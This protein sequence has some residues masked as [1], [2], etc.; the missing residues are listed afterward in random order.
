M[1]TT[2]RIGIQRGHLR[3]LLATALAALTVATTDASASHFRAGNLS[4][5]AVDGSAVSFEYT[6]AWRR[7]SQYGSG[8]DGYPVVGDVIE[9]YEGCI[10]PE[11]SAPDICPPYLV[12]ES[13]V[14]EDWIVARAL[15]DEND[16]SNFAV[17][18]SYGSAFGP[19]TALST[20]CCTIGELSN[21]SSSGWQIAT[22]VDLSDAGVP[23]SSVAP[24]VTLPSEA[25]I[26]TFS[27]A[28][29]SGS[30]AGGNAVRYR[31]ATSEEVCGSSG[32][33]DAQPP[34]FAV[35]PT[36]GQAQFDTTSHSGLWY[37]GVVIETYDPNYPGQSST[38]AP[39][40][41][42]SQVQFI[43]R[44]GGPPQWA[45]LTPNDGATYT[46][47]P[48]DAVGFDLTATDPDA[49]ES[50]E[51]TQTSGPG[52]LTTSEGNPATAHYTF[53]ASESDVGQ[54][55]QA[56]FEAA[57]VSPIPR[58]ADPRTVQ[59]RVVPRPVPE[60][61]RQVLGERELPPPVQGRTANFT[62]RT[63]E[64][65]V[66]L[67]PGAAAKPEYR[68][69][70]KSSAQAAG[71]APKG[72]IPLSE[73]RQLPVGSTLDTRRG[74][75]GLT[76]AGVGG[77][78]QSG[79]FSQG[80]FAWRQSAKS[81]LTTLTMKGA[82]SCKKPGKGKVVAAASRSRSIFGSGRGRFRTRGRRSSAT[83]RGTKWLQKDTCAGTLTVVREGSVSVKDLAK[84]KPIVLKA[85]GPKKNRRH[86]ARAPKR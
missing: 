4:W 75:V 29:V 51:I 23:R 16:L 65:F 21:V 62:P 63:G 73:A 7:S 35:D 69:A 6:Q 82:L 40:I 38:P 11:P 26:Q 25:G 71:S 46:V 45:A 85:N 58:F 13:H 28:A 30:Y 34:S 72:F 33:F 54:T 66:K 22:K 74:M 49:G 67:P 56:T 80:L 1:T 24:I 68:W 81:P 2:G 76:T 55:Y 19:F 61:E 86:F 39:A 17:P 20:S 84:R 9:N 18:H 31:L 47:H 52:T 37:A 78:T 10:T 41:S 8:S 15:A 83:V 48:G 3:V 12:T 60:P 57:E 43:L 59:I 27:V 64:V 44:V 36:T 14:S 79:D 32:C 42:T 53:S 50:V 70:R 77:N 5:T